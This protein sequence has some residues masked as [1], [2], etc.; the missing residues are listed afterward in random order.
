MNKV[1]YLPLIVLAGI[2]LAAF[3]GA[4]GTLGAGPVYSYTESYEQSFSG[5]MPDHSLLCEPGCGYLDWSISRSA[6]RA[7]N[8]FYSLKGYL[9]GSHDA[10][11][12]WVERPF[13]LSPLPKK[14]YLVTLSFYV[15]SPT[16]TTINTWPVVAF[17]AQ[18]DP[19][20]EA[21]FTIIGQTNQVAGWKQYNYSTNLTLDPTQPLWVAYGFGATGE[22][23]RTYYLDYVSLN[24]Y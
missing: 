11:A 10:G 4:P 8:G 13:Y 7:Y 21:D 6:D 19:E 3:R 16:A 24:I 2:L 1:P 22:V 5:W 18:R 12:L 14:T 20:T 23:S 15:W 17:L 9:N